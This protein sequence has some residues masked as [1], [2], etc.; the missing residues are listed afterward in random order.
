MS[1][2]MK[3]INEMQKRKRHGMVGFLFSPIRPQNSSFH[4]TLKHSLQATFM[5]TEGRQTSY[6]IPILESLP[7]DYQPK[8]KDGGTPEVVTIISNVLLHT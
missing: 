6:I 4:L 5:N 3:T 1:E 7:S 2:K 8:T